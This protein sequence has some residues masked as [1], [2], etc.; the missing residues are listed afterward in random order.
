MLKERKYIF[1][2]IHEHLAYMIL[3]K[4]TDSYYYLYIRGEEVGTVNKFYGNW[5][6]YIYKEKENYNAGRNMLELSTT[7]KKLF[8]L[9]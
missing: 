1:E 3:D 5:Y 9:Y 4:K 6:I 2:F 8:K 7:I